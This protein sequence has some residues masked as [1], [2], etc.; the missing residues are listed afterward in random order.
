MKKN[1]S[2]A[3]IIIA[4]LIAWFIITGSLYTVHPNQY[5]A[6]RQFGRIV[7]IESSPGL[8]AK[9]PFVQNVQIISAA[10]KLYDVPLSD[11]ITRDKK[12]MIADNYVLWKVVDPTSY[13]RTLDA[14]D[15]R[16]EERI[17]AAVYNA[18]KNVISSL[19]QDEVIEARGEKLTQLLTA[20]ANSDIGDYGIEILTAEIKAL[21]LPDDNKSAVYDRMI[22]ER[23]NI[24]ASY[25]AQGEAE[26]QKIRNETD[27]NVTVMVADANKNAEILVAEGEAEYMKI[28]Q[29]A[30]NTSEKADFY[31][32]IRSLDALKASLKGDNKTI[33]LDKD[34]ELAKI[35]YGENVE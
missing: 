31:N 6:I 30:Y 9:L 33:I 2:K 19:T 12:S 15:A 28:L 20:E 23:Q 21:D 5:A 1:I 34:S 18:L 11:V 29:E 22:S 35:L 3:G 32:F 14:I 17:E 16:A 4:V 25:T 10:T 27:K 7:K 13:I 26:A 24:A 8:K